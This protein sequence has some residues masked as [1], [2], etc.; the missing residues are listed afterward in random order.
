MVGSSENRWEV[1]LTVKRTCR[2]KER[3]CDRTVHLKLRG[4]S[5]KVSHLSL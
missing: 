2:H 1:V 3:T 4:D 5:N